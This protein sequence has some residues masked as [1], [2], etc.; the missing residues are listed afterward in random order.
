MIYYPLTTLVRAGVRDIMLVTGGN[1]AGD[2][3]RLLGNGKE[4]GLKH[5]HYTYQE[6]EGGIAHA[7]ALAEHFADGDRVVVI[8]GDNILEENIRPYLERFKKQ[9][10]GA[11]LLLKRVNDPERFGVAEV[12]GKKI[13]RIIEK[14]K[15]PRSPYAVVG[16]Y[17]YDARVFDVI[18]KLKPSQRGELEITDVNNDY[19]R[20]GQL[21]YDILKGYWTDAGT[22]ES[23]F[24]ANVLV[25]RSC[26]QNKNARPQEGRR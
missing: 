16:L 1:S 23:L 2:F 22:F 5:I 10:R 17:M 9:K 19:I 18:K 7:L 4:F 13:V 3:L 8:L 6:G 21:E 25:R 24:R 15:R 20:L 26:R 11:R 12:R 14:P